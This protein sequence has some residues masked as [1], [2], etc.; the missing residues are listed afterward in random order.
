MSLNDFVPSMGGT[1]PALGDWA[2]GQRVLTDGEKAIKAHWDSAVKR[3]KFGVGKFEFEAAYYSTNPPKDLMSKTKNM[4]AMELMALAQGN[5]TQAGVMGTLVRQYDN[6]AFKQGKKTATQFIDTIDPDFGTVFPIPQTVY[7]S[8]TAQFS[9]GQCAALSRT[10]ATAVEQGKEKTLI[11]N[12]F[13]A[14][15]RP[16]TTEAREFMRTLSRLQAFTGG[17][18]TFHAQKVLRQ[19]TPQDMV[20]ELSR[21]TVTRSVMIDSPGH[22]MAAGVVV[23]GA[24]KKYYFYDPNA[25]VAFFPSAEA[26]ESGLTKLF[27]DKRL[28]GQYRT[29]GVD[30][31]RL[32]F[33]IFDHDDGW[34]KLAS[35]DEV[36]FK[37]LFDVPLHENA[38]ASISHERLKVR[39]DTL[40]KVPGNEGLNCYQAS[41]RV[42]Q[43]EH[44]LTPE[45]VDAV[46]A[47]TKGGGAT[48]YTPRYLDLMGITPDDLK[49][50][51][52][53]A[54]IKESG[55]LNFKLRDDE[56]AGV[57][58]RSKINE[59]LD[60]ARD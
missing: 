19:V 56:G 51:F 21:S 37:K 34:R 47:A 7:L 45:A 10:L 46:K 30:P 3:S 59:I 1:S 54:E 44:N 31:K 49:T 42:A 15:A 40:Q 29:H 38:V 53:A 55:F 25:G 14:A 50:T 41:L 58:D 24:D 13:K 11:N 39:W 20:R 23:D 9:D 18:S 60:W 32:E 43:A 6:L 33:K 5:N 8:S 35:I 4:T 28:Q 36:S 16:D 2:V 17:E 12:L 57:F 26:M 27:N 52:N 22:A 48:S